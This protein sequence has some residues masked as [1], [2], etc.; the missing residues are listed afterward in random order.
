MELP[1]LAGLAWFHATRRAIDRR[2][3]LFVPPTATAPGG[4]EDTLAEVDEIGNADELV[5]SPLVHHRAGGNLKDKILPRA[6]SSARAFAVGAALGAMDGMKSKREKR[7]EMRA[8]LEID[9]TTAA[10][11][12]PI[13]P[14]P[15]HEFLP[16]KAQTPIPA[17][18][19]CDLDVDFV[20]EHTASGETRAACLDRGLRVEWKYADDPPAGAVILEPHTSRDLGVERIVFAE[21]DVEARLKPPPALPHENRATG[22]DVAVEPLHAQALRVTVASVSRTALSLL[23][24]HNRSRLSS[25]VNCQLSIGDVDC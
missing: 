9:R 5:V 3:E 14:A 1:R 24:G 11:V 18:T 23:M 25:I 2:R 15:R 16:T 8:R 13:G 12:T 6:T 7:I 20:D 10:A 17:V 19:G 21:S 4:H 22:D